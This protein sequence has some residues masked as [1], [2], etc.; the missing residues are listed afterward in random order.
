MLKVRN[1]YC[2]YDGKDVIK[3]FNIDITR[4]QNVSIVGPNGCGKSTL[5]KAM[6]SLIDYKGNIFLDGKEVKSIKRKELAKKVA[7]M[8]QN[9]QIY[10]PYTV[11]ETVALGR[12]AHIDGVFA[13]LSKKDEEIIL[14]CLSN[15]GILD[16]KDKLINELS[17]G[18]LQRVYLA[19]VF[20]QEPDVILLDE[21]TNHLDLKCQ[22][23]ILEHINKWTKENQKTVIGVLHDLNLVQ[24]FSDD[25][26]MLSEGYIVSK[27]KTKDVLSEDKLKE[28]YGVD[29]KK[30]MINALEKWR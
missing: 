15:V 29:I 2:G 6:V 7:L 8:S 13:R 26:I 20:A 24:M 16:L 27:G 12:Y 11:Y 25:V 5:L 21:P 3:D 4:G 22:I 10:F 28:V 14:N 19:R 30:F 18:Q 9:S 17:G 23:E 1:L